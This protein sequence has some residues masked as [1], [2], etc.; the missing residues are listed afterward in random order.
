MFRLLTLTLVLFINCYSGLSQ[1]LFEK[2]TINVFLDCNFCDHTYIRSTIHY[3]NYVRDPE[4]ADIHILTTRQRSGAGGF[5]YAFNFIGKDFF[6]GKNYELKLNELPNISRQKRN[7][8]VVNK[9]ETGLIPY[10]IETK[11]VDELSLKINS[12]KSNEKEVEVIDPWN[13]W[14]FSLEGGGSLRLESSKQSYTG[15]GR[16]RVNKISELWRIRNN[17]YARYD[18]QRFERETGDILSINERNNVSSSVVRSINDHF[19][20]GFFSSYSKSTFANLDFETRIAPAFEFS[21]FPYKEVHHREVTLAY[22]VN[23]IYRNY[24]ELT[25]YEKLKE[26]LF[27]QE[28]VMAARFQ[29]PWGS[30]FFQMRGSHYLHDLDQNRLAT[31]GNLSLRIIKGLSLTFNYNFELIQDQRSLPAGDISF[32]ELLLAQKQIATNFRFSTG[33]SLRYTFGSIYNNI[34][35]TRL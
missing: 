21:F 18:R 10:W 26:T 15:W 24:A 32:E 25:I 2:E 5:N 31:N 8:Q 33:T 17:L 14:V 16:I 13:N 34:V 30:I 20:F 7:Q 29:Q 6:D 27:N 1:S 35:N 23:N 11:L 3:I 9:I 12:P 19:S 22:R 4:L 28:L